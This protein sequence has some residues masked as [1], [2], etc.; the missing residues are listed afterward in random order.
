MKGPAAE[1]LLLARGTALGREG[2]D[3]Q[4]ARGRRRER[5]TPLGTPEAR[6]VWI[7]DRLFAPDDHHGIATAEAENLPTGVGRTGGDAEI[8]VEMTELMAIEGDVGRAE[9]APF[10]RQD[11]DRSAL[12]VD[13]VEVVQRFEDAGKAVL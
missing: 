6:L 2:E 12:F 13:E 11:E 3:H 5:E 4:R 8:R 7:D 1:K 9:H 10:G